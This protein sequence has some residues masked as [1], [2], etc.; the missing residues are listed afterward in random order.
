MAIHVEKV[1]A[2][3]VVS[4]D[5]CWVDGVYASED[6]ARFAVSLAPEALAELWRN[7]LARNPN[8]CLTTSDLQGAM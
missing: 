7:A 4:E 3:Y 6:A 8:A 2:G 5:G 1:G